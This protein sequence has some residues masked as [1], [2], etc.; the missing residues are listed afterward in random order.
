MSSSNITLLPD[1]DSP[2]ELKEFLDAFGFGMQKKFGQNFL[3]D[4]RVRTDLV[5]KLNLEKSAEGRAIKL[6]EIGPGLG[7]MTSLLLE[8][9][10]DLTAF[11]ID[12]GFI[13][14]LK[15]FFSEN[16][17]FK[18]VEGDVLKTWKK[19][20]KEHG[21]PD[22]FFGNLP[23]NIATELM[24][25]SIESLVVFDTALIT[26]QKEVAQKIVA[27]PGNK[28][29]YGVLSVLS[30]WLYD[31]K[32]VKKIPCS[33]FWPQPHIES[34][35]VLFTA[36]KSDPEMTPEQAK[37]FIKIVKALFAS[38]RKTI[39]NNL[40]AFLSLNGYPDICSEILANAKLKENARAEN[41]SLYEF[42]R[43]S[44]IISNTEK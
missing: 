33:A 24:L 44:D 31:C 40:S 30:N 25:D 3:I 21:K 19:E 41:L 12:R 15:S 20:L 8:K 14:I 34:A 38:R 39:K 28:K 18:L 23:Y 4:R 13:G 7:A 32:I 10:V 36:K 26:I 11:E 16:Q 27:K 29:N 1:Y 2:L 35:T 43:L 5:S 42:L 6:W 22:I 37:L 9:N 17:N